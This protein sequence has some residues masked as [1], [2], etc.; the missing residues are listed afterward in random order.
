[1]KFLSGTLIVSTLILFSQCKQ[2]PYVHG[3]ILYNNF[4]SSCHMEDGKGLAGLIPPLLDEAYL[5]MH[6]SKIP[7]IIRNGMEGEIMVNGQPY[8]QPMP[9]QRKLSDTDITNIINFVNTSWG[10][11]LEPISLGEVREILETCGYK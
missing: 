9:G 1:M 11:Q 6:R 3:E 2:K 10:N 5:K 7:C 4:C 8:N